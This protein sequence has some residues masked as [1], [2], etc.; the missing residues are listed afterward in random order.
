[1][2]LIGALL[3]AGIYQFGRA[4]VQANP[5]TPVLPSL[6]AVSPTHEERITTLEKETVELRNEIGE[7]KEL[8]TRTRQQQKRT[9]EHLE[10]ILRLLDA[11]APPP[12]KPPVK[13]AAATPVPWLEQPLFAVRPVDP[14]SCDP[15]ETGTMLAD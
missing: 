15:P 7:L 6:K 8:V 2:A 10:K 11:S 4:Q 5:V 3:T 1:M 9:V 12:P 13:N 14:V